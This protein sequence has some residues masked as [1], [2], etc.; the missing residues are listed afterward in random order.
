ME[1]TEPDGWSC[2]V[3]AKQG[4]VIVTMRPPAS[5]PI[6]GSD[7]FCFQLRG[8]TFDPEQPTAFLVF[9]RRTP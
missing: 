7:R 4:N 6:T 1:V 2:T 9:Q 8:V 5:L 3:E